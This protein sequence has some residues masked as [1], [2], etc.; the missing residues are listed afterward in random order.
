MPRS[1]KPD[2]Q[3]Q[4]ADRPTS[5]L[6]VP[7]SEPPTLVR[8]RFK[9]LPPAHADA[10]P[11]QRGRLRVILSACDT[12]MSAGPA[13]EAASAEVRDQVAEHILGAL[14][15]EL[16]DAR[17]KDPELQVLRTLADRIADGLLEG[18]L[19]HM[20]GDGSPRTSLD[21]VILRP[22]RLSGA[23]V[24]QGTPY[25]TL[26]AKLADMLD[27]SETLGDK[28]ARRADLL[29]VL[30][31]RAGLRA[32]DDLAHPRSSTPARLD[33]PPWQLRRAMATL[34]MQVA[35]STLTGL[36]FF[37][38]M[39]WVH[40]MQ[41]SLD[42]GDRIQ[43]EALQRL[44]APLRRLSRDDVLTSPLFIRREER[45]DKTWQS[46]GHNYAVTALDEWDD[47]LHH[48]SPIREGLVGSTSLSVQVA[49]PAK[50]RAEATPVADSGTDTSPPMP[51]LAA[52]A[53]EAT[54]RL[55]RV[56]GQ[57]LFE[58]LGAPAPFELRVTPLADIGGPEPLAR[59]RQ[60]DEL[61]FLD[62]FCVT[63][64]EMDP[65]FRFEWLPPSITLADGTVKVG[66]IPVAYRDGDRWRLDP[67]GVASVQ[68]I[69]DD[70]AYT[71]GGTP[72]VSRW[73]AHVLEFAEPPDVEATASSAAPRLFVQLEEDK[74]IFHVGVA[75][76]RRRPADLVWI[77]LDR[78]GNFRFRRGEALIR[79]LRDDA[80]P[81]LYIGG[82]G[83]TSRITKERL[84]SGRTSTEVARAIA[85]LL[86]GLR[87]GKPF[88]L[89]QRTQLMACALESGAVV[90]S[91]GREFAKAAAEEGWGIPQ[92]ETTVFSDFLVTRM[93]RWSTT[94]VTEPFAGARRSRHGSGT[95]WLFWQAPD[96]EV[97][98]RDR[99]PAG[100]DAWL[101]PACCAP[102]SPQ[103]LT[104]PATGRPLASRRALQAELVHARNEFRSAAAQVRVAGRH[105]LPTFDTLPGGELQLS[106]LR[107]GAPE[108][109]ALSHT[110]VRDPRLQRALRRGFALLRH[111][112]ASV[113]TTPE[114][115]WRHAGTGPAAPDL[116]GPALLAATLSDLSGLEADADTFQK[117]L[118]GLSLV[119]G[120]AQLGADTATLAQALRQAIA[121]SQA[122]GASL[123]TRVLDWLAGSLRATGIGAQLG[124]VGMDVAALTRADGP[125]QLGRAQVRLTGDV[126][127]L[128]QAGVALGAEL[129][130]EAA[131]AAA[132]GAL[133][134]PLSGLV[135]GLEA[136]HDAVSAETARLRYNLT[137]LH[138][139]QAGYLRPLQIVPLP[140]AGGTTGARRLLAVNGW[141]A[142]SRIDFAA[143]TVHFAPSTIGSSALHRLHLYRLMPGGALHEW[144]ILDGS[145]HQAEVARTGQ[146][147]SLWTMMRT[148][149]WPRRPEVP[150]TAAWRD[151]AAALQLLAPP[152]W[153]IDHEGYSPSRAGGGFAL[154][155]DPVEQRITEN[156]GHRFV[157][158]YVTSSS[159]ARSADLWRYQ[160]RSTTLEVVLDQEA[161]TLV[162][163]SPTAAQATF[164]FKDDRSDPPVMAPFDATAVDYRLVGG[165]GSCTLVLGGGDAPARPVR[166]APSGADAERWTL[167]APGALDDATRFE[168][169][170]AGA[171]GIRVGHQEI[172]FEGIAAPALLIVDP[173]RPQVGVSVDVAARRLNWM[174]D[175][176]ELSALGD[177][178]PAARIDGVVAAAPAGGAVA[179]GL[180]HRL[181][182]E[183]VVTVF[184]GH[185]GHR[186][187]GTFTRST[188]VTVL[189][190]GDRTAVYLP[191]PPAA[192]GAPAGGTWIHQRAEH[193][194][195]TIGE[196][197]WPLATFDS[198]FPHLA[199]MSFGLDPA[200]RRFRRR[201][202]AL[203]RSGERIV[204]RWLRDNPAW[205]AERL[206]GFVLR[207]ADPNLLTGHWPSERPKADLPAEVRLLLRAPWR[208]AP[209]ASSDETPPPGAL[210]SLWRRI[211][212]LLSGAK[213]RKVSL[214]KA[215]DLVQDLVEVGLAPSI[216][217]DE[218]GRGVLPTRLERAALLDVQRALLLLHAQASGRLGDGKLAPGLHAPLNVERRARLMRLSLAVERIRHASHGAPPTAVIPLAATA[219]AAAELARAL[220][221][222]ID[223]ATDIVPPDDRREPTGAAGRHG[224]SQLTLLRMSQALSRQLADDTALMSEDRRQQAI[225]GSPLSRQLATLAASPPGADGRLP[226][227]RQL[228]NAVSRQGLTVS[229]LS[230]AS[231]GSAPDQPGRVWMNG[232]GPATARRPEDEA[233]RITAATARL[234]REQLAASGDRLDLWIARHT[235]PASALR[236]NL[237]DTG[238]DVLL[239]RLSE[240]LETADA[241]SGLAGRLSTDQVDE[242]LLLQLVQDWLPAGRDVAPA[243]SVGTLSPGEVAVFTDPLAPDRRLYYRLVGSSRKLAGPPPPIASPGD[244]TVWSYLGDSTLL[245]GRLRLRDLPRLG[246]P[247][248]DPSRYGHWQ[249]PDPHPRYGE[250]Y[251]YDNPRSGRKE[252]YRLRPE[253]AATRRPYDVFPKE[254]AD[255]PDWIYLGHSG[256]LSPEELRALAWKGPTEARTL[257]IP[258]GLVA[259]W[260]SQLSP[261]WR[262]I[263]FDELR[264]FPGGVGLI[265]RSGVRYRLEGGVLTITLNRDPD[266]YVPAL[267]P[268]LERFRWHGS[269]DDE[270]AAPRHL[271]LQTRGRPVDLD[272]IDRL[273]NDGILT[274]SLAPEFEEGPRA[275]DLDDGQ[276]GTV[277]AFEG[278]DLR[279]R[280]PTGPTV[281]VQGALKPD[282]GDP[283][284]D[285]LVP[286]PELRL[287][288]DQGKTALRGPSATLS[289]PVLML[290][291][292]GFTLTL[293]GGDGVLRASDNADEITLQDLHDRLHEPVPAGAAPLVYLRFPEPGGLRWREAGMSVAAMRALIDLPDKSDGADPREGE[294]RVTLATDAG[295]TPGPVARA[296]RAGESPVSTRLQALRLV[297]AMAAFEPV[298]AGSAAI[299]PIAAVTP[300]PTPTTAA[301]L[302]SP[303]AAR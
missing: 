283:W 193:G 215:P 121:D 35:A 19:T 153:R 123:T 44:A 131:T 288:R 76:A 41:N 48:T 68:E 32:L 263:G 264:L 66:T 155:G 33:S 22:Q 198:T 4:P 265:A 251:V 239:K 61:A 275:L 52:L 59:Q 65:M 269:L 201:P 259:W 39:D 161:R 118:I 141:A 166:I 67:H 23:V 13:P 167:A 27:F 63:V 16:V 184:A 101:R 268:V 231:K 139:I 124:L 126:L 213:S 298:V 64:F 180:A 163:P 115:G 10:A 135:I 200:T 106:H 175:L 132:A 9:L 257:A 227:T 96:G 36:P 292:S 116:L 53:P 181:A 42:Q 91:F 71:I 157:G 1:T 95:T 289:A 303:A 284:R 302:L 224:A 11:L 261:A 176:G 279:I 125:E 272:G 195:M 146:Q 117:A 54:Q 168:F 142:L 291:G 105:L 93:T 247:V 244:E 151:P 86:R 266:H 28:T 87:S 208:D 30:G 113:V 148:A 144:D 178:S 129:L 299:P 202:L 100:V 31:W 128:S 111:L 221:D 69:Y 130:G 136:L 203:D 34:A 73:Q 29:L 99:Y 51:I 222:E 127:L 223:A 229:A 12:A 170:T 246:Q 285:P 237:H 301:T 83:S 154:A 212:Q 25:G 24:M 280:P 6:S 238:V 15:K 80:L 276:P 211:D 236:Q 134:T 112:M 253:Q 81:E 103:H 88:P 58:T 273:T 14:K 204:L 252:L 46:L 90:R 189:T 177:A 206:K 278:V 60:D 242:A 37:I 75:Q 300:A 249:R 43:L 98:S 162:L 114:A 260:M 220:S 79:N 255:T 137:P 191:D 297:D 152:A 120:S 216:G 287:T 149:T 210:L 214:D 199:P 57:V 159:F 133:A 84:I 205:T 293:R 241:R 196:N 156:S 108:R 82:H 119:S 256:S 233:G 248:F 277:G 192:P 197:G 172:R 290:P 18:R 49:L 165:G 235:S 50:L 145:D 72:H 274:V 185:D 187:T 219:P 143:G 74:A 56:T 17:L 2:A 262:D 110:T 158:E 228:L 104:V 62:A 8:P 92:M 245:D 160:A 70:N 295:K 296:T 89:M 45:L 270:I 55:D 243:R 150:M 254:A 218:H 94:H 250:A 267:D 182:A 147:R 78:H 271:L 20:L 140:D 97:R 171:G 3:P 194:R 173:A 230:L 47:V 217:V 109:D 26:Q 85:P 232:A 40:K 107:L 38:D 21:E 77:Q 169:L 138:R 294:W 258:A 225:D 179:G 186:L 174:V 190:G 7:A 240:A 281:I 5:G 207:L 102:G 188:G 282:N 209:G 164:A 234:W 226:V 183:P 286:D 122:A